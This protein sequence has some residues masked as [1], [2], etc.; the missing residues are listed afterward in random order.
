MKTNLL[1]SI[2]PDLQ[3]WSFNFLK[4]NKED[5]KDKDKIPSVA[6]PSST[7]SSCSSS[8]NNNS[9]A[10]ANLNNTGSSGITDAG[11]KMSVDVEFNLI[12]S[13]KKDH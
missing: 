12:F 5:K 8:S 11:G 4:H 7:S 9:N 2:Q 13:M 6:I 10:L 1:C 3:T